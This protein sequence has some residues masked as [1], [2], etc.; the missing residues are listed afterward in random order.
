M[1]WDDAARKRGLALTGAGLPAHESGGEPHAVQTLRVGRAGVV[2]TERLHGWDLAST[3][4]KVWF[5]RN[6]ELI[7]ALTDDGHVGIWQVN[8]RT[9][10]HVIEVP[11]GAS[12]D[13]AGGCFDPTG[14]RFVASA[15]SEAILYDVATGN[16]PQRWKLHL[17][18]FDQLRWD[19]QGRLLL[20][21]RE[22]LE[23]TKRRIWRL[24][25]LETA[26]KPKLLLQ[27]SVPSWVLRD[28]AFPFGAKYIVAWSCGPNTEIHVHDTASGRDL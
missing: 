9:L 24:Y 14:T 28:L 21:R 5:S 8:A 11:T 7:A 2:C 3:V 17:G 26:P 10:L 20:L 23:Q 27:Q 6:N 22:G 4:R 16:A 15:G 18:Y 25:A 13:S 19:D 1:L 12:A